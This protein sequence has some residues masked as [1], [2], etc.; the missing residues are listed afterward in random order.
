MIKL[1]IDKKSPSEALFLLLL[2][3]TIA[4][5]TYTVATTS[6]TVV[7]REFPYGLS[8]ALPASYWIAFGC[9]LVLFLVALYIRST[10]YVWLSAIILVVLVSG[11]REIL[12]P[13][14]RDTFNL[15]AA[16]RI[17]RSG[18]FSPSQNVF[19][20]F[21]GSAVLFSSLVVVTGLSP[22][23]ILSA[24]GVLYNPIVLT[25]SYVGFS[26]MGTRP[27]PSVLGGAVVVFSFYLQGVLLYTSLIGF[28]FYIVIFNL[29]MAPNPSKNRNTLLLSIF[30]FAMV[31]S[32]AF[33]PFLT[34]GAIASMLLLWRIAEDCRTSYAASW[35]GK[36]S[37]PASWSFYCDCACRGSC[38][39]LVILRLSTVRLGSSRIDFDKPV[40]DFRRS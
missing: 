36:W 29:L 1:M 25:L 26:R 12:L 15:V 30:F 3:S 20:N 14:P 28:L 8:R 4:M 6:I 19:L 38:L 37:T 33:S 22:F 40:E 16:T 7:P 5:I 24:F 10:N 9:S 39:I 23:V 18:G 17:A 35:S 27:L 21:P 11:L 2:V 13:I 31:V 32:H 34:V